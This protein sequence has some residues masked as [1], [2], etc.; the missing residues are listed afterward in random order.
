M[1]I[2]DMMTT[3]GTIGKLKTTLEDGFPKTE[4]ETYCQTEADIQTLRGYERF[5]A[6][7]AKVI[8]THRI[9]MPLEDMNGQKMTLNETMVLYEAAPF[10]YET[11]KH[12]PC[13][14]FT[15]VDLVRKHHFEVLAKRVLP[16]G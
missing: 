9:F 1:G 10:D 13:Y 12:L 14:E 8:A 2:K 4:W 3:K 11:Q 5:E 6:D 16:N 7:A 15:L